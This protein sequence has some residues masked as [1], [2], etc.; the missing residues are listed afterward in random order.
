MSDEIHIPVLA[1]V[2][3]VATRLNIDH[4]KSAFNTNRLQAARRCSTLAAIF[5]ALPRYLLNSELVMYCNLPGSCD[6]FQNLICTFVYVPCVM[7][8]LQGYPF[9]RFLA[10]IREQSGKLQFTTPKL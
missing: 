5:I 6:K 1:A 8:E 10:Q 9:I 4:Y 2:S 7:Y 3:K